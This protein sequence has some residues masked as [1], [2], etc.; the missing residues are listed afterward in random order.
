MWWQEEYENENGDGNRS[1]SRRFQEQGE[2]INEDEEVDEDW[3]YS[4]DDSSSSVGGSNEE[5]DSTYGK[6][7]N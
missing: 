2:D 5:G 7:Q 3:S 4:S 1:W 6:S